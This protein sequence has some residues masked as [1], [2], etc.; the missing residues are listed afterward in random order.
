AAGPAALE[1]A[2][3]VSSRSGSWLRVFIRTRSRRRRATQQAR[4]GDQAGDSQ[5]QHEIDDVVHLRDDQAAPHVAAG[6]L[7]FLLA[8]GVGQLERD[9][10]Q[11]AV[12]A[13]VEALE[14]DVGFL[15]DCLR[16]LFHVTV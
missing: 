10:A 3:M 13:L 14:N 2:T 5:E 11:R 1:S 12:R 15:M 7:I 9:A 6:P 4:Q 8:L 16:V